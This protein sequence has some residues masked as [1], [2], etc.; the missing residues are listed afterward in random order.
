MSITLAKP[1][2]GTLNWDSAVNNNF[3]ILMN[4][5]N[6]NATSVQTL[7]FLTFGGITAPSASSAGQGRIYYD[8]A[9][10]KFRVSENA[11]AY[12]DLMGSR[13]PSGS[14][15]GDLAGTFPNPTVAQVSNAF[16]LLNDVTAALG[17]SS[18]NDYDPTAT[19]AV[20]RLSS[21]ASIDITGITRGTDGRILLIFNTG[22]NQITLRSQSASSVAANRFDF[23]A[24]LALAASAGCVLIYDSTSLRWRL[25]SGA[26]PGGGT[27]GVASGGT[28]ISS[29]TPYAVLCGG[30]TSTNPLQSLASVGS[31][32][33]VLTSN[34]AGTLPSFQTAGAGGT[35]SMGRIF[36]LM[37]A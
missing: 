12:A 15:G 9:T 5:L 17:S 34:G 10:N 26:S 14:A 4:A 1:G 32:G 13:P 29:T 35:A 18:Q 30:T 33:Q 27:L 23:S 31:S 22:A 24:D 37:G 7:G 28:G 19:A 8:S 36:L 25:A 21:S 20:L 6:G 16:S 11:V 2:T 3:D